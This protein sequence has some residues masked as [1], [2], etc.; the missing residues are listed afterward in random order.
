MPGG[1]VA[2]QSF[3]PRDPT[4]ANQ[5]NGR[6]VNPVRYMECGGFTGPGKW[7]KG[8]GMRVER[9]TSVKAAHSST[10]KND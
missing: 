2:P 6:I 1:I 5:N 3:P 10:N 8:N 4:D 7:P 9:P